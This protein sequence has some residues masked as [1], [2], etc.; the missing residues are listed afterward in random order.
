MTSLKLVAETALRQIILNLNPNYSAHDTGASI[1]MIV[2]VC[3]SVCVCV[4]LS[5][6]DHIF[7]TT[8]P[9]FTKFF[10]HATYGRGS[11]LLWL[12]NDMLC[13]LCLKKNKTLNSCP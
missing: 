1:M 10:T 2:S 7:G 4:C 9:I 13:T 12:R 3:L 5:V 8:R 11:V 6:H